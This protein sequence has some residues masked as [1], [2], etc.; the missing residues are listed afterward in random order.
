MDDNAI[1]GVNVPIVMPTLYCAAGQVKVASL[2]KEDQPPFGRWKTTRPAH[3]QT[4]QT[5]F[6]PGAHT[7]R[8]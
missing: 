6:L 7:G 2:W 5:T 3:N 8:F 1:L 4:W